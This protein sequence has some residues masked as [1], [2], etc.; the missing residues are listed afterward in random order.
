MLTTQFQEDER[1]ITNIKITINMKNNDPHNEPLTEEEL[2]N[3]LFKYK[4]TSPG[5]DDI[6]FEFIK[7]NRHKRMVEFARNVPKNMEWRRIPKRMEKGDGNP[8]L[9]IGEKT[10]QT[11]KATARFYSQAGYARF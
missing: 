6:H 4:G 9:E 1:S 8:Y 5:P 10:Q 11:R 7:K 3:A 2:D